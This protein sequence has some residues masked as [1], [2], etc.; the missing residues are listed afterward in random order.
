M[1]KILKKPKAK[2]AFR[3]VQTRQRLPEN[4]M[5][6]DC[7]TRWGS[8]FDMCVRFFEQKIAIT[9]LNVQGDISLPP[10]ATVSRLITRIRIIRNFFPI[11]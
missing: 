11:Q 6:L 8:T 5:V 7:E 3:K 1:V 9:L 4:N 10:N 2:A